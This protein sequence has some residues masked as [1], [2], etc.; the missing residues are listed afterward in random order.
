MERP[1]AAAIA[2]L[3][4]SA[5]AAAAQTSG[6]GGFSHQRG[7]VVSAPGPQRLSLDAVVLANTQPVTIE[8]IVLADGRR[9]VRSGPADLRFYTSDGFEVP[10]L[11]VAPP[12]PN[13]VAIG[14]SVQA[15]AATDKTSGFEADFRAIVQGM[16]A[17]SLERIVPP[18]LKRFRLEGSGDRTRW[19]VLVAEGTAFDLPQERL[20]HVKL[21]FAPGA[22]RYLRVTWDDTNSGRVNLP[23]SVTAYRHS[24]AER[25]PELRIPVQV[26]RLPTEPGRSRFRLTLPGSHLPIRALDL[27]VGGGH[28]LRDVRVLER[29][30]DPSAGSG[31]G[32]QIAY[33]VTGQARLSRV[34]KDGAT[35]EA[36]RVEIKAPEEP[37][38][39]LVVDDGDNPPL[40]LQ[41]VTAVFADLPWIYFE[42][43]AGMLTARFGDAK[44]QPPRYDLEAARTGIPTAVNS[45]TWAADG[46][47]AVE[48][49]AP[50]GLAMPSRGAPLS[51][52]SFPYVR[53]IPSG[54]SGL[55]VVPLDAAVLAHSASDAGHFR[56]VRVLDRDGFQV[57]YVLEA[58]DAPLALTVRLERREPIV[59]GPGTHTSYTV[60]V[61]YPEIARSELVLSTRARVFRRPVR[62]GVLLPPDRQG[63]ARFVPTTIVTW[64]QADDATAAPPLRLPVPAAPRGTIVVD[65]DEGDNQALPIE[66]A[67]LL[68]PSY[69]VR[70]FRS[71]PAP[72]LLAYGRRDLAAPTYDLSLLA[73]QLLGQRA[74]QVEAAPERAPAAA[75]TDAPQFISPVVFWGVLGLAVV[76]LLG[77]VIRLVRRET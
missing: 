48:P 30:F 29:V 8:P 38:V 59:S 25:T 71:D 31:G 18:F 34:V 9:I 70:F 53:Q 76:V 66:T 51:P 7:V 65:V 10:Y 64:A 21:A 26:D 33:R 60:M 1:V 42:S 77:L 37:D 49:A 68:V 47:T 36:L 46:A 24:N 52:A 3:L 40:D 75:D 58:R 54:A 23:A 15:I 28:L 50:A 55:L 57:P 5:A 72:L 17:V 27:G 13:E 11:F 62:L 43:A 56:D 73:P 16:D 67:T 45:A 69:A 44:R 20:R 4:A 32:P 35:A 6:P 14:G 12:L 19:T 2:L 74:T 39:E 61:P 63:Q 41:G 22:Y